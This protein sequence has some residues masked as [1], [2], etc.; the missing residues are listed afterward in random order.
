V[1]GGGQEQR[2]APTAEALESRAEVQGRQEE[3]GGKN[4]AGDCFAKS[5]K[6]RD[7]TIKSL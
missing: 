2:T 4:E 1:A 6:N 5:E 3:E 7:L